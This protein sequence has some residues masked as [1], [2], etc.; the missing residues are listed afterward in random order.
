MP[1]MGQQRPVDSLSAQGRLADAYQPFTNVPVES[2][3]IS[4]R[5]F[6]EQAF[7]LLVPER[8]ADMSR[9]S[10]VGIR[11]QGQIVTEITE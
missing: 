5:S 1:A 2:R 6:P 8:L 4:V 10:D 3:R 11:D 7:D 9:L